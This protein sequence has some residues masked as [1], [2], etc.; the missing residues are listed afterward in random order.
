MDTFSSFSQF[1]TMGGYAVYVWTAYG[2]AISVLLLNLLISLK[3][4]HQTINF[5]KEKTRP[6]HDAS[7]EKT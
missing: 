4:R 6:S 5:F 3:H 2:I 1:L 7:P